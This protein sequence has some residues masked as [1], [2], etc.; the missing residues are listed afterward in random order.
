[1][2]AIPL[3]VLLQ[4]KEAF[5]LYSSFLQYG[6]GGCMIVL[7][8]I[9]I[10]AKDRSHKEERSEWRK[11]TLALTE[12][13]TLAIQNVVDKFDDTLKEYSKLMGRVEARLDS[14]N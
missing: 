7:L 10:Y 1:M 11:D 14:R 4:A 8:S 3:S 9:Y 6:L 13:H 2:I 5:D 12:K